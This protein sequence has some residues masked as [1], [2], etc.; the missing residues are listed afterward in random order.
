MRHYP[1]RP[2]NMPVISRLTA[3][4]LLIS[5]TAHLSSATAQLYREGKPKSNFQSLYQ[6]T[7]G[8][9]T[10]FKAWMTTSDNTANYLSDP[11]GWTSS[12]SP[13]SPTR[14]A[15]PSTTPTDTLSPAHPAATREKAATF[16]PLTPTLKRQT[17]LSCDSHHEVFIFQSYL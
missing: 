16:C 6:I 3:V 7:N 8:I 5:A 1:P 14:G 2:L 9:S 17:T 11:V 10:W 12:P 15:C 4:L 13:V